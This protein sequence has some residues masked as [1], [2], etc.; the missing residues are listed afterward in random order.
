[1]N[2]AGGHTHDKGG[3]SQKIKV[4]Q[5][6]LTNLDQETAEIYRRAVRMFC[7]H[8]GYTVEAAAEKAR[9]DDIVSFAALLKN[10]GLASGTIRLYLSGVK[11]FYEACE[12]PYS[13]VKLRLVVPKRRVEKETNEIP[14]DLVKEIVL[15]A[16]PGKR[17]LFHFLWATGARIGEA[18]AVRKRDIA[19]GETAKVVIR[20]EK[21]NRPR[22][23]FLPSDLVARLRPRLE[24]IGDDDLV[25][26]TIHDPRRPL[27]P[28][29]VGALFRLLLL[30]SGHLAKDNSGRG[31]TFSLHSFRRSF[32][33][34]LAR[35]GVHP[36]VIK[37]LL[38]HSQGVEDHYLRLDEKTLYNEWRKAE[39]LLRLDANAEV[40]ER[41][42]SLEKQVEVLTQMVRIMASDLLAALAE[43]PAREKSQLPPE[44]LGADLMSIVQRIGPDKVE[45]EDLRELLLTLGGIYG[46][47]KKG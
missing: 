13:A 27:N 29:K 6:F 28:N 4:W 39:R 22:I 24:R 34:N 14:K 42:A 1:M 38:G 41:V 20:T 3:E 35:A 19:L 2:R 5:A 23:V 7:D 12:L 26:S 9:P 45:R 33:T 17:P 30:R 15:T 18:L 37:Y 31:Y 25:F 44:R 8:L 43:G 21:T 47:I 11:K 46:K 40:D 36:M 32:E 16:P 10:K